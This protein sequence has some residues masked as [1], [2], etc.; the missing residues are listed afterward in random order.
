MTRRAF[1]LIELITVIAIIA[2][3]TAMIAG[4]VSVAR[5]SAERSSARALV[6]SMAASITSYGS[7]S[8][9]LYGSGSI[10]AV[11]CRAWD[12]DKDAVLD[13][14]IAP[15]RYWVAA[16]AV[17]TPQPDSM[18]YRGF[19]ATVAPPGLRSIR[20][21][22]GVVLD[23]WKRHLHIAWAAKLYGDEGFCVW[24]D[25]SDLTTPADDIRSREMP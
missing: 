17:G 11:S 13:G 7:R 25:G 5:R 4:G 21:E 3:L 22:D 12:V 23:P 10:D 15:A 24:S 8:L 1:T 6:G 20:P 9:T 18:R 2:V 14:V 16:T 19:A